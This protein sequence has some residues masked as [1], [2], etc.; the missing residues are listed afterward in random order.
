M[1]EQDTVTR[2]REEALLLEWMADLTETDGQVLLE[3]NRRLS[4]E[5]SFPAPVDA[6]CRRR[7]RRYFFCRRAARLMQQSAACLLA[8]LLLSGTCLAVNAG[9]GLAARHWRPATNTSEQ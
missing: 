4:R 8:L 9:I 5:A 3:E 2:Q 1:N 7:I 6:A